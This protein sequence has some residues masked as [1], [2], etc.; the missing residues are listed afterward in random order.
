MREEIKH[1]IRNMRVGGG[2]Q[3][4]EVR[5]KIGSNGIS[6][7]EPGTCFFLRKLTALDFLLMT[8]EV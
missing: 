4:C 1:F 7:K 8:V 2:E 5:N 3:I 6:I